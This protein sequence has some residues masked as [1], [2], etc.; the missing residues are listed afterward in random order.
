MMEVLQKESQQKQI[1]VL[2]NK[3]SG[4]LNIY[5]KV[6]RDRF[7]KITSNYNRWPIM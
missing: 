5:L 2:K 6:D 1:L 7:L 3:I 4:T